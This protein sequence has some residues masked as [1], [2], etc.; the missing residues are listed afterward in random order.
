MNNEQKNLSRIKDSDINCSNLGQ[1]KE[2]NLDSSQKSSKIQSCNKFKKL[3]RVT[4]KL[5]TTKRCGVMS[6]KSRIALT[7]IS[8]NSLHKNRHKTRNRIFK[9]SRLCNGNREQSTSKKGSTVKKRKIIKSKVINIQEDTSVTTNTNHDHFCYKS[10]SKITDA[11]NLVSNKDQNSWLF[12]VGSECHQKSFNKYNHDENVT[13][14][15]QSKLHNVEKWN[16]S[17]FCIGSILGRGKFGCVYQ[18]TEKLSSGSLSTK[19]LAL[20]VFTKKKVLSCQVA[21]HL[22]QREIEIHSR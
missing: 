7:D 6:N 1:T 12:H 2:Q 13:I 17:D 3:K 15:V 16:A 22:L 5:T 10:E 14:C 19:R 9:E 8:S 20:K 18:A 11:G 21:P 4:N